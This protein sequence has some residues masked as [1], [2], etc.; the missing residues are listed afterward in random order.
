MHAKRLMVVLGILIAG[1]LMV[2]STALA[3]TENQSYDFYFSGTGATQG[4]GGVKKDTSSECFISIEQLT[5]E[6]LYL[7]ID[8]SIFRDGPWINRTGAS[9]GGTAVARETGYFLIRNNV[10]KTSGSYARLT[11]MSPAGSGYISGEWS[12]DTNQ[13]GWWPYLV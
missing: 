7:Y 4:T 6:S 5:M 1:L 8:G 3:T 13:S 11:G 10:K 2:P 9:G 12:P